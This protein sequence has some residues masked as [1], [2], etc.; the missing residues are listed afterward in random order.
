[1][2][3]LRVDVDFRLKKQILLQQDCFSIPIRIC[4]GGREIEV[5]VLPQQPSSQ[6]SPGNA[7]SHTNWV[8]LSIADNAEGISIED[9]KR[10]PGREFRT[11]MREHHDTCREIAEEVL[12][13][14]LDLVRLRGQT[15]LGPMGNLPPILDVHAKTFDS[16]GHQFECVSDGP[17]VVKL[18]PEE[19]SLDVDA[20]K[21]IA[22][23]L[24]STQ[25]V[26]PL[27][28]SFL[29]DANHFLERTFSARDGAKNDPQRAVLLAAMACELKVKE[30][31]RR[32]VHP[33]GRELVEALLSNPR[34][35][36]MSA[37]GLF[38]K[39]MKAATGHSLRTENLDL[40]KSLADSNGKKTALFEAR[41]AI[42][43]S[44][45]TIEPSVVANCIKAAREVFVWLDGIPVAFEQVPTASV[46]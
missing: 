2:T 41:N 1:M 31:L 32:K 39:A 8:R 3:K 23:S 20:F 13:E 43:H 11:R 16:T 12:V 29:V 22:E 34:D 28:E 14:F 4:R 10:T 5:N 19:K 7:V 37:S 25:S 40:Y 42:V 6:G 24:T 17:I 26:S 15:W 38:D 18:L 44:G 27:P 9:E 36:S 33:G 46:G 45:M 35:F 30:T 21:S